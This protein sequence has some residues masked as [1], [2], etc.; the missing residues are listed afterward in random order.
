MKFWPISEDE[1]KI[2]EEVGQVKNIK[3]QLNELAVDKK[4]IFVFGMAFGVRADNW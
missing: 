3:E 4:S 1:K 2:Q